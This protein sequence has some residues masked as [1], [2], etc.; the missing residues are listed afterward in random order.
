MAVATP[1][2]RATPRA[3]VAADVTLTRRARHGAPVT[4]RTEDLG[5][6]GM[7]IT[8]RRPLKVDERL[9]FDVALADGSHVCGSAHVVR[10]AARDVYALC[11]DAVGEDDGARL[12]ALAGP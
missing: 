6:G 4:G 7:R 8:T 11:I 12:W 9:E 5:P 2:R 3:A 1:R 10:A